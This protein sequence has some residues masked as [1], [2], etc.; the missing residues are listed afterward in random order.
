MS[1]SDFDRARRQQEI[2]LAV[3]DRAL[4]ADAIPRWPAVA[5]AILDSV[6]TDMGPAELAALTFAGARVDPAHLER[7]VLEDPYVYGY[8]RADGAAIQLP[9]WEL[10]R[11]A[12]AALFD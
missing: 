9:N 5:A 10:I 3:R 6:K 7:L 12:V 11:P 8:R 4:T 1:T 2:I